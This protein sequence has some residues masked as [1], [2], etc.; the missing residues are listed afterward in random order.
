MGLISHT[1]LNSHTVGHNPY[2]MGLNS[3]ATCLISHT[4]GLRSHAMSLNSHAMDL[5]SHAIDHSVH[6]MGL[7]S[8]AVGHIPYAMDHNPQAVG[9]NSHATSH[10]PHA[11]SHNLHLMLKDSFKIDC[12]TDKRSDQV[13]NDITFT[14]CSHSQQMGISRQKVSSTWCIRCCKAN[15]IDC[16]VI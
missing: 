16:L 3:H 2:D 9:L 8:H 11:M 14:S 13:A 10:N 1:I 12:P 5:D 15:R 4:L 6:A 7:N